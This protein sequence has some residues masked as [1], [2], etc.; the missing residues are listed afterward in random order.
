M[1]DSTKVLTYTKEQ[2]FSEIDFPEWLD[3]EKEEDYFKR[4]GFAYGGTTDGAENVRLGV[5][6]RILSRS[7]NSNQAWFAIV[8]VSDANTSEYVAVKSNVDL[9]NLRLALANW[10]IKSV[11]EEIT[12]IRNLLNK[13]FLVWHGHEWFYPCRNCDPDGWQEEQ[14]RRQKRQEK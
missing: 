14:A 8:D 13:M 1:S 10:H 11:A 4:L 9:W 12:E 7:Q 5:G 2:G 6:V 3:N